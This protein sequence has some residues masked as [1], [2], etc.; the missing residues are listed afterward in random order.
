[1]RVFVTGATGHIG[2]S[3]IRELLEAGHEVDGL[4][5]SDTSAAALTA[6]GAGVQRG[7]LDDLNS[8][9]IGATAADGVI[10]LA[11]HN[12]SDTTDFAMSGQVDLRAVETI[13]AALEGTD[14][15]FVITLGRDCTEPARRVTRFGKSLRLSVG[16]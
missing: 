12:L 8:L 16:S 7:N 15:P 3:L 14:K 6:A 5:R 9:R 1:M 13:G 11:F 4:A 2:S 10:H